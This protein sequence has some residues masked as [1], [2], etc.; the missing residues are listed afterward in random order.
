MRPTAPLLALAL[1]SSALT[2]EAGAQEAGAQEARVPLPGAIGP[3]VGHVDQD[4]ALLWLRA[5]DVHEVEV[6]LQGARRKL[7]FSPLGRGCGS[8]RLDGLQP[9]TAYEVVARVP[10]QEPVT[11]AFRTAPPPRAWGKLRFAVGS[12][13]RFEQQPVWK[14]AAAARPE[15]FLFLGDN[16][17]YGRRQ[18]GGNDWERSDWMLQRQL[19]Q[20][21]RP[22]LLALLR[23]TPGYGIWDDHDYGGNDTDRFNPL[24]L[25]ARAIHRYLWAANPACGEDGEGVYF[26]FRRGPVEFF[27][28]DGRS[29]K[30][31]RHE[32][33]SPQH[34][35]YGARQL[36]WLKRG[37]QA[38][39][40]PLKVIAAGTQLRWS[41]PVAE[42]WHQ[43]YEE[44]QAF[45]KWLAGAGLGPVVL[46][47]GDV[48]VSELN[49]GPLHKDHP[50]VQAWELT[51]SGLAADAFGYQ[52]L[53]EAAKR[54]E[55][56][57]VYTQPNV[58]VIEVDVPRD[59]ARRAAATLRFVCLAAKDGA[60]V[61]E[62]QTTFES[63]GQAAPARDPAPTPTPAP[64]TPPKR[65]FFLLGGPR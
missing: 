45:L 50:Q 55:R 52:E 65:E 9:D 60:V 34:V 48:H 17:Y 8:L 29:F 49:H 27:L 64:T 35:L 32:L 7:P 42:G 15:L 33:R 62:T 13:A 56:E 61:K 54:P 21:Q 57:W 38:S 36:A 24:R 19:L 28:L 44:Q 47:S 31:V 25:E 22:E 26:S 39:G 43:A 1:A 58:C 2:Q 18:G 10:G 16:V 5:P 41:Y 6:E 51:S 20:R 63:F 3:T 12:C 14:V 40:A 23:R 11:L 59:P 4:H 53:F 37:L 46:L 30:D